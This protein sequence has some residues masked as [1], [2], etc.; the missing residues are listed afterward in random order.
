MWGPLTRQLAFGLLC[1]A[2]FIA[3]RVLV[4][5]IAPTAGP[6]ALIYPTVLIATLF[7]RWPAGGISYA[8]SLS[9]VQWWVLP[10]AALLHPEAPTNP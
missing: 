8:L 5:Q 9:W 7:G 10:H 4:D 1:T 2:V 6:F 3:T